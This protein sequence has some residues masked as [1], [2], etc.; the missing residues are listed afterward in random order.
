[1]MKKLFNIF[2]NNTK[3]IPDSVKSGITLHFPQAIN[4]EWNKIDGAYEAIFY[5]NEVEHIAKIADDGSLIEYKKNLW[6]DE[7]PQFI[8]GKINEY[9]EMMSAIEISA[10]IEKKYEII[11]RKQDFNR[12]LLLFDNNGNLLSYSPV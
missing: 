12:F 5:L 9:G 1:M 3:A 11:I 6:L 7:V 2:K 8:G 10:G 4:V